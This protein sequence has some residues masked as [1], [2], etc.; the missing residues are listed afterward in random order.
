[1]K[2]LFIDPATI[3]TDPNQIDPATF[4]GNFDVRRSGVDA[5]LQRLFDDT[6]WAL[7]HFTGGD[8]VDQTNG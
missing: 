1:M 3:I 8:L 6:R 2:L 7:D 4:N 5:V